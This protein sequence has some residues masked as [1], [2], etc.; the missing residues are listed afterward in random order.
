MGIIGFIG[1]GLVMLTI[2]IYWYSLW[3]E[4]NNNEDEDC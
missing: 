4:M 1:V 2:C 3:D